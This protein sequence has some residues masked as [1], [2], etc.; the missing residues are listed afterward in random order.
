[1]VAK[2]LSEDN[3]DG[4]EAALAIGGNNLSSAPR[5]EQ[6]PSM[7]RGDGRGEEKL[8]NSSVLPCL[9]PPPLRERKQ[10]QLYTAW[11]K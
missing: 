1:M 11:F 8:K 4:G 5:F 10:D 6:V 3:V 2:Q 9:K 7:S